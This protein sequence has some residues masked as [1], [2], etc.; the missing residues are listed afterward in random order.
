MQAEFTV[1]RGKIIDFSEPFSKV[2]NVRETCEC[3]KVRVCMHISKAM[4]PPTNEDRWIYICC[5][6]L[7][8]I[9]EK[10]SSEASKQKRMW[11]TSTLF[12]ILEGDLVLNQKCSDTTEVLPSTALRAIV[13]KF[14]G[15]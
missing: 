13:I 15:S 5:C 12:D 6:E 14:S 3:L 10:P 2:R 1:T 11:Y 7:I 9:Q 4:R 8:S